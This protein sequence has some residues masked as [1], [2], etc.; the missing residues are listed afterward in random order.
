MSPIPLIRMR[1]AD[2]FAKELD[3]IGAP[4]EQLLNRVGLS[5]ELLLQ[6]DAFI[7][8]NQLSILTGLA[9]R[10]T[11][12]MDLG[13]QAGFTP[14]QEHSDFGRH[15][16]FAP[17]L[18]QAYQRLLLTAPTEL[19]NANFSIEP[20]PEGYW[21]CM[22]RIDGAELEV[23]QV[24]LYRLAVIAQMVRWVAGE[25]WH[26]RKIRMQ[27]QQLEGADNI[28]LI[29]QG[30]LQLGQYQPA[31]LVPHVYLARQMIIK[32]PAKA[33]DPVL[34][35]PSFDFAESLQEVLKP[36]SPTSFP[37]MQQLAISMGID[38][39]ELERAMHKSG[40]NYKRLLEQ[41]RIECARSLLEKQQMSVAQIAN[42]LGYSSSISFSRAFKRAVGQAPAAFQKHALVEIV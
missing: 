39:R 32:K 6:R 18:L 21:F 20:D 2:A 11:G 15:L 9:A 4:T 13:L 29:Q 1:Y 34:D 19:T 14:L 31:L 40:L 35:L 22:G 38:E 42:E 27:S 28:S 30:E 33:T 37:S 3:R 7:P 26:P 36:F 8:F 17:T 12:M 10:H 41:R 16:I 25:Q 23:Q 24:E 5:E